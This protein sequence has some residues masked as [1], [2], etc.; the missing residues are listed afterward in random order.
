MNF[1]PSL[2][3]IFPASGK[4]SFRDKQ[5]HFVDINKMVFGVNLL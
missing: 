2:T 1:H 4:W 5:N 3:T